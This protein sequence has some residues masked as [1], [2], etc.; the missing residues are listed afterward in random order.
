MSLINPQ[1]IK[2]MDRRRFLVSAGMAALGVAT[3][4]IAEGARYE[5]KK[6]GQDKLPAGWL[7]PPAEYS[8]CPFWF[9]NDEL[10]EEEIA[11]QIED[12]R[13]H[14]VYGFVIHPRA[15][16]PKSIGWMSKNMIGLPTRHVGCAV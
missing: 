3:G 11:R 1:D 7:N 16:L 8:L 15:G 10:S 2:T 6:A 12:F 5:Q 9:W 13:A 4:T 14:G